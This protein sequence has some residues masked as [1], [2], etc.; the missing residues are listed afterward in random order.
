M[1]SLSGVP[2]PAPIDLKTLKG[3]GQLAFL[4]SQQFT[5]NTSDDIRGYLASTQ[6]VWVVNRIFFSG[7]R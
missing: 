4:V 2:I 7:D 3:N 1:P 5:G 6:F